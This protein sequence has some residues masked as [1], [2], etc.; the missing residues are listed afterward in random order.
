M[1]QVKIGRIVRR[2][3]VRTPFKNGV[4]GKDWVAGFLKRNQDVKLRTP[5]ALSTVRAKLLNETVT[6]NFFHDL[7]L[8]VDQLGLSEKPKQIWNIDET[9]VPLLHKPSRVLAQKGIKN[10]PGR[11]GNNRENISVLACINAAGDEV[12]PMV[13]VKGKTYKSLLAYNTENGVPGSIYT[14]QER[15]WMED[16]L[17]EVWFKGHFLK[18]CGPERPQLIILDSHSSHETRFHRCCHCE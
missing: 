17:G 9:S 2:L 4:P 6:N 10:L 16:A 3:G 18:H 14:Y 7:K 8:L 15:A 12:P 13:I 11:V 1:L 5:Q